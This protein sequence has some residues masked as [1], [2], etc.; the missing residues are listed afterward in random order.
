M[1]IK[2]PSIEEQQRIVEE[3]ERKEQENFRLKVELCELES[4]HLKPFDDGFE[5]PEPH[6]IRAIIKLTGMSRG[7]TADFLG[8]DSRQLRR[9]LSEPPETPIPYSA[10]R[11]LLH[12][13][14]LIKPVYI[15]LDDDVDLPESTL[16][17]Y[18]EGFKPPSAN[19]LK[20][21]LAATELSIS[22]TARLLGVIDRTVKKWRAGDKG[23]S[24]SSWRLLLVECG[25]V[26]AG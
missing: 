1:T 12:K 14:E 17:T 15:G 3:L 18:S 16:K 2:L 4:E 7:E 24:Y 11:L 9:Y 22:Q 21:L 20:E 25:A 23:I 6:N 19:K 13:A 8:V 5:Q 26:S 10:Y